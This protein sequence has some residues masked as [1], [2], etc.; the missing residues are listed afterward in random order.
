MYSFIVL[1]DIVLLDTLGI[2][3]YFGRDKYEEFTMVRAL[4]K[5]GLFF[6][7]AFRNLMIKFRL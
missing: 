7:E 4:I 5:K 2:N 1:H 6:V 3:L